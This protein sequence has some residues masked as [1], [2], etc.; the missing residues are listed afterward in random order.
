MATD[1]VAGKKDFGVGRFCSTTNRQANI[2]IACPIPGSR[3]GFGS[4]D[5]I[6]RYLSNT[7][8]YNSRSK[9]VAIGKSTSLFVMDWSSVGLLL[10]TVVEA[11]SGRGK[12]WQM[13]RYVNAGPCNV[14]TAVW[15]CGS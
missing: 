13:G 14:V 9:T 8:A 12:S 6:L 15:Q 10:F 7:A 3:L 1:V 4:Y 2:F 11:G 5:N